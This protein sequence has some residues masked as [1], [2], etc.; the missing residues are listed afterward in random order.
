MG[1]TGTAW[2]IV[3][4]VLLVWLV[5]IGLLALQQRSMMYFPSTGD[6]PAMNRAAARG[7]LE[8]WRDQAG[9]L[10]GYTSVAPQDGLPRATVLVVH[11]NAGSAADRSYYVPLLRQAAPGHALTVRIL[12]YPGYGARPGNPSQEAFI[13]TAASA[14][15][16]LPTDE[17]VIV[18][19]ES[20]GSGVAAGLAAKMPE[21][22]AGLL[23]V[24]PFD[25]IAAVAQHHYPFIPVRWILRDQYPSAEW[26]QAYRGPAAF[27]VAD[28]DDI[29]PAK[30][31]R[32]LYESF[33]GP[34]LL[35]DVPA[36]GHNNVVGALDDNDWQRA[37]SFVLP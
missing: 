36:A 14:L 6:E 26:L 11:G 27:I 15:E 33:T 3:R 23:M 8:P 12:E 1:W 31:G 34:K 16:S 10:I 5:M 24:T 18:L 32:K 25:S 35:L 22:V 7:G 17:P 9:N 20:I 30:F 2:R 4:I 29:V 37:L 19:G 28:D 13:T 21:R